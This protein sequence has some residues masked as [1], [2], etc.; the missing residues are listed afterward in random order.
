VELWAPPL[1]VIGIWIVKTEECVL[2]MQGRN[3]KKTQKEDA[4]SFRC[5]EISEFMH[6]KTPP[7]P[8]TIAYARK[9]LLTGP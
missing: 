1:D 7:N 6:G 8:D 9:I 5:C 2:A 4:L 3:M